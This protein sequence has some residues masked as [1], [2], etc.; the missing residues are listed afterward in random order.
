MRFQQ[1]NWDKYF[2][3]SNKK[4]TIRLHKSNIGHHKAYSGSY[5]KPILLG[6]F[7]IIKVVEIRFGDLTEIETNLDGFKSLEDL[8]NELQVLNKKTLSPDTPLYQHWT[9]NVIN[10]NIVI[11]RE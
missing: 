4:T 7:D 6:E 5:F 3:G 9:V 1:R 2:D 8:K 11:A 10:N